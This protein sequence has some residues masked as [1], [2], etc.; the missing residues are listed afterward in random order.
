MQHEKDAAACFILPASSSRVADKAAHLLEP[1]KSSGEGTMRQLQGFRCSK[2]A[3]LTAT[4]GTCVSLF[5]CLLAMAR[6]EDTMPTPSTCDDLPRYIRRMNRNKRRW[7]RF[8]RDRDY[9]Y[10]L[11]RFEINWLSMGGPELILPQTVQVVNKGQTVLPGPKEHVQ[12][13][14]ILGLFEN[15][16]VVTD[17]ALTTEMGYE[18]TKCVATYNR[19]YGYPRRFHIML[20]DPTGVMPAFETK[21][22]AGRFLVLS[23]D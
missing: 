7:M 16:G 12:Y 13:P 20:E 10:W 4:V 17:P 21:G 9:R 19:R 1:C 15:L 2:P 3:S 18:V 6:A 22:V 23:N 11:A 14:S 5:L 8:V